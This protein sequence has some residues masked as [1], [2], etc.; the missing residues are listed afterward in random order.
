MPTT[1]PRTQITRGPRVQR[2]LAIGARRMP[3]ASPGDIL[4]TLAEERA[5]EIEEAERSDDLLAGLIVFGSG[6][7]DH[8]ITRQMVEDALDE[9]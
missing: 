6:G 2:I 3:G 4:V 5:R 8:A 9:D 1:H 7:R